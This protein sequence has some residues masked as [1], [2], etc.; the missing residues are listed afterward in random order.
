MFGDTIKLAYTMQPGEKLR[1]KT[2]VTSEQS[3]QQEGQQPQG[4]SST[5]EM[6]ML[7]F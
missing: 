2:E 6:V 5:M 1:Y 3:V 7:H 4:F